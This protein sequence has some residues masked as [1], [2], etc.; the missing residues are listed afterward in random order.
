MIN[1]LLQ[2]NETP[3]PI[4]HPYTYMIHPYTYILHIYIS[5]GNGDDMSSIPNHYPKSL[6]KSTPIQPP[7]WPFRCQS[8]QHWSWST[9]ALSP[10]VG[11]SS[12]HLGKVII[13]VKHC[14]TS[15]GTSARERK[16]HAAS[17][18]RLGPPRPLTS[19]GTSAW[20]YRVTT[21]Y[22]F[23]PVQIYS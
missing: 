1:S 20:L 16:I 6:S 22:S 5:I 14:D 3:W 4:I 8:Q 7:D 19:R 23:Y 13:S 18:A 2:Q 15:T 11:V 17:Y 9:L 21:Q 10:K 12:T